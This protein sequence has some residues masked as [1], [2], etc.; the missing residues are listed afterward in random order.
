MTE[1]EWL[2]GGLFLEM[3]SY[4]G[5]EAA[6]RAS[7]VPTGSMIDETRHYSR[8]SRKIRLLG[9]AC[10]RRVWGRV[11]NWEAKSAVEVTEK[12]VDSRFPPERLGEVWMAVHR[13]AGAYIPGFRSYWVSADIR[14]RDYDPAL[15]PQRLASRVA[16]EEPYVWHAI[17]SA[18]A[19]PAW[20]GQREDFSD[21]ARCIFGN[22]FRPV[23]SGPWVTPAAVS[24][25]QDCYDRRDFTALPLLADLLE[26]AG[27]PEQSVLDHC[28]QPGEHARGC[29][30]VDLVLGKG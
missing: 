19:D 1:A 28:R 29:W 2:Q 30:V 5:D 7:Q 3:L 13:Y 22:P 4:L 27:C 20:G 12:V 16:V 10:A 11:S 18:L 8:T 15:A 6:K 17:T 24:V 26:E 9:C 25:A 21:L 14:A 23:A